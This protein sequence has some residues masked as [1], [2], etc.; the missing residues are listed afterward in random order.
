MNAISPLVSSSQHYK[1]AGEFLEA[2]IPYLREKHLREKY[3]HENYLREHYLREIHPREASFIE[4]MGATTD[5]PATDIILHLIDSPVERLVFT[6]KFPLANKVNRANIDND[7]GD[8]EN[9]R[10]TSPNTS[11]NTSD[12]SLEYESGLPIFM[13]RGQHQPV[14]R[15]T[16]ASARTRA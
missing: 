15:L 14:Q 2:G 6:G 12:P 3:R 5:L 16:A 4:M 8:A 1:I 13:R 11:L 9:H 7:R 10:F